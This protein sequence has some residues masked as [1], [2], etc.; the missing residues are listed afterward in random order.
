MGKGQ[1]RGWGCVW[2]GKGAVWDMYFAKLMGHVCPVRM[3]LALLGDSD[4]ATHA[5]ARSS[6]QDVAGRAGGRWW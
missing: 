2:V 5:W 4:M 3:G 1:A 6:L